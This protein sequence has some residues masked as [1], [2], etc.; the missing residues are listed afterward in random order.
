[1][2]ASKLFLSLLNALL[3]TFRDPYQ[4]QVHVASTTAPRL[5][6]QLRHLHA[7]SEGGHVLFSDVNH[8]SYRGNLT[9]YGSEEYTL[10]T[11]LMPTYR[12]S[13]FGAFNDARY[14]SMKFIQSAIL[15]WDEGETAGPDIESRE[16][17]LVLAKMTSNAYLQPDDK[18]WYTLGENW[19][20]GYDF[21]WEPDA[22]GFR[23]HVFTTPDNSTV[24]LS[25]KGTSAG[26]LGGGGPTAKKDK[27]NDN[28]LFSC[29]C[30]KVDW[31][32]TPVCDCHRGGWKC[33]QDCLEY[34]LITES[35]FYQIGTNLYNN[36]SYIYPR[37]D[38]WIIGHSLGGA[39]A[40]LLGVTFGVPVVTFESPGERMASGRLHLPSPPSTHHVTHVYHTADPVPMGTCN[41]VLSSCYVAGFALESRCHLGK[42]VVYDTVSNLSW[43]VDLRTHPIANMIDTVLADPWPPAEELGREVPEAVSQDDCVEC[44][45]WEFGDFD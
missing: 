15:D 5:T 34:S 20:T 37:S 32:W 12:P 31:S 2:L 36:L 18:G 39:L 4:S 13:S 1:M 14:R 19:T 28:L 3:P 24:V 21:G 40:S 33:S 7:I 22:D 17:L 23:G 8:T 9:T 29:C 41:G 26:F 44:Y 25:I 6:F 10:S 38:I 43:G 11:K 35:L 30:A 16:S 27:L 45:S 42:T